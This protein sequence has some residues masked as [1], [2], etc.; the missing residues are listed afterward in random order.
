MRRPHY[1][2]RY[3][4][5]SRG[6]A[7]AVGRAGASGGTTRKD[8]TELAADRLRGMVGIV[9]T[10]RYPDRFHPQKIPQHGVPHDSSTQ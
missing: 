5:R 9:T 3:L 1:G 6:P 8:R 10:A 4:S 7:L 2:A